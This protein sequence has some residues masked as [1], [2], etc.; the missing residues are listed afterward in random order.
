MPSM[1]WIPLL[2]HEDET[3]RLSAL[4]E[5]VR[6]EGDSF[7]T[8]GFSEDVNNHVHTKYSFSPYSPAAVAY[9]ARKNGLRVVGSVDHDSLAAAGEMKQAAEI[10]GIGSTVGV[11]IRV[12]FEDTPFKSR[13]LNNPDT[14]GNAYIVFHGVPRPSWNK[15]QTWLRPVHQA[16]EKRNRRMVEGINQELGSFLGIFDYDTDIV[17]LSW[18]AKGGSVT[19]RHLLYAV[20]LRIL[21]LETEPAHLLHLVG[22]IL[23]N[24]LELSIQEKLLDTQNPHRPYDLLGVLKAEF[25]SRVFIQP[26]SVECPPVQEATALAQKTGSIPAYAYLGDVT[27]SPTGDKKAQ[28]FEDAY[29]EELF[30][31]L[32]EVGFQAVT[33]MPPRNTLEQLKRVQSL[34]TRWGLL[35]ISGVDINSSR[36]SFSCPE[37]LRPE[38]RHLIDTTW[39]LVGQEELSKENP[40]RG[41]FGSESPFSSSSLQERIAQYARVGK[42]TAPSGC[43]S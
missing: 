12:S 2:E 19:E 20:S 11:E 16:R 31:Y 21:T 17:P 22:R 14:P 5:L 36:Q 24:S 9:H 42:T 7:R 40:Y 32:P 29:L 4:A 30:Q 8:R 18:S 26:D 10:A 6:K 28:H 35:E 27:S 41:I 25:L 23:N 39:S 34:A 13:R 38:F 43:Y 15:I 1:E 37:I 3:T 33:Y